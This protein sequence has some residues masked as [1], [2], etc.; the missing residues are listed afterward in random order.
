MC[1]AASMATTKKKLQRRP[2]KNA[3]SPV[4]VAHPNQDFL[5]L[6]SQN[7]SPKIN[8]NSNWLLHILSTSLLFHFGEFS[9][10]SGQV[11]ATSVLLL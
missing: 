9:F 7:S 3:N 4:H 6:D 5:S 10:S 1:T 8:I 11:F 2:L